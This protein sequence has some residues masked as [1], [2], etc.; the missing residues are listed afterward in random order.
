MVGENTG[1]AAGETQPDAKK[2]GENPPTGGERQTSDEEA[3]LL[4]E[5]MALKAAAKK[6]DAADTAAEA[7]RLADQGE[8]K[9][10]AEKAEARAKAATAKLTL[11]AVEVLA[12]QA[13]IIDTDAVRLA[14][15]STV[16]A[17]DDGN[18]TGAQEA[19]EALKTAKPYLFGTQSPGTKATTTPKPN[20]GTTGSGGPGTF[21]EW[22]AMPTVDRY[23]WAEKNPTA[24]TALCNAAKTAKRRY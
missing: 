14:D 24:Y 9:T 3:K 23:T 18:V 22:M 20:G 5:V 19:I 12:I 1:N 15:L 21:D 10:L 2:A 7:K 13:G 6:R 8:Y 17:D 4:K 16:S 11:K